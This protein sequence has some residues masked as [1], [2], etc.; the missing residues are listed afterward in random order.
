MKK[1]SKILVTGSN[2][3]L[4]SQIIKILEEEKVNHLSTSSKNLDLTNYKSLDNYFKRE[5]PKYI[6]HTAN[7]VFGIGGNFKE[8]FKMINENLIINSN[9][10]KVCTNHKIRKIV[11]ISSAAIYSEKFKKNINEN[12]ALKFDPHNSEFYY[13][14][15]KRV[16][17]HQLQALYKQSKINFSYIIMNNL[18]G[19]RDNFNLNNGHVVPSLIHKFYLAK[20]KNKSVHLWGS[21]KAKRCLLYSKDAARMII[22][23]M[24]KNIK[25]INLS[26]KHEISIGKL[27]KIISDKLNYDGKIYWKKK[28]F[29][30]VNSRSLNL[31]LLKKYNIKENYSLDEGLQETI[32]WFKKNYNKKIRK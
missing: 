4:G 27:A 21:P 18:Y 16:M 7:K 14:I 26:S 32:F 23:I 15:S 5:K 22:K 28:P 3:L 1:K 19:E 30:S 25:I 9:L 11:F 29:T 8:K 12:K 24:N 31:D 6:I 10:L 20:K 17:L 2:G 13:G